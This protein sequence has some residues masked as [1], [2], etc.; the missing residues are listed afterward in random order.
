MSTKHVFGSVV[1]AGVLSSSVAL[2]HVSIASGP[3]AADK[4]SKITFSVGH[5]CEVG[6]AHYDTYKVRVEIPAGVTSVRALTSDFGKPTFTKAGTAVT[7][8]EWVK[9][10]S[11]IL[12]DD[13]GYYEIT[14]RARVPNTPFSKIQFT[15]HQV[16][17][18]PNGDVTASWDQPEGATTG[19]PAAQLVVVPAR[20]NPT[21]WN[22]FTIPA[23]VTVPAAKLGTYFGDALIVWKGVAA[24]S[25]NASTVALIAATAGTTALTTDL[26]AGDEVWVRY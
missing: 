3:A 19:N 2:A 8:I 23:G 17:Q 26:V 16:C 18:T 11:E 20:L 15:V 4:S 5:G 7:A 21:G 13:D 24:Y 14:I 9:P 25:A 10:V 22:K 6:T 1:L 12:P